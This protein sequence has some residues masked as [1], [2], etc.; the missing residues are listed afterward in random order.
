M[1]NKTITL[2]FLKTK[3]QSTGFLTWFKDKYGEKV[4]LKQ[5][6]A[7]LKTEDELDW[8]SQLLAYIFTK[9]QCV[10]YIVYAAEL[11]LPIHEKKFPDSPAPRKAIEAA[12]NWLKNP[13]DETKQKARKAADAAE[14]AAENTL[15]IAKL[16][17]ADV[18]AKAGWAVCKSRS[19]WTIAIWAIE[20]ASEAFVEDALFVEDIAAYLSSIN[21]FRKIIM[22]KITDYGIEMLNID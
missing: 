17:S 3:D 1:K 14:A 16:V 19:S 5:L 20:L 22:K 9:K 4:C 13:C 6:I 15:G 7:D 21:K 18:C 2:E 8:L 10:M 11:V 12:K